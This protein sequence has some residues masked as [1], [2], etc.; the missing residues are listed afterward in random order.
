MT[1]ISV[2]GAA[3]K[4]PQGASVDNELSDGEQLLMGAIRALDNTLQRS[5]VDLASTGPSHPIVANGAVPGGDGVRRRRIT[6]ASM[7][8]RTL[9]TERTDKVMP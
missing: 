4:L 6:S 7:R 2:A 5:I 3:R 9:P 1:S 8:Q